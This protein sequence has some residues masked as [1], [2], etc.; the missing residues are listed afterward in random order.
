MKL[1]PFVTDL[2][3][4]IG[5]VVQDLR[6]WPVRGSRLVD[7]LECVLSVLLAIGFA[8]ALEVRHVGW[9]AFSGYMVM[10][11][12]IWRSFKRGSLRVIGTAAGA[13]VAW[14]LAAHVLDSLW[15]TS[16]ALLLV[17]F[18]TLYFT[19]VSPRGYA[20]L[21]TGLTF[22]MVLIDGMQHPDE[23]VQ[24]FAWTRF[25]EVAAGTVACLIVS[26]VSTL[27]VRRYMLN[28]RGVS[29]AYEWWVDRLLPWHP[30]AFVHAWQGA[31]AMALIPLAWLWLGLDSLSQSSVT[32]MVVMA[33]PLASVADNRTR[34]KLIHRFVGCAMGA[35]FAT[36]VLL[37]GRQSPTFILLAT[38]VAVVIGRHIENG[39][40]GIDYVGTQFVLAF[41]VVS[42]PDTYEALHLSVGV[43]R[44]AGVLLGIVLLEPVRMLLPVRRVFTVES[45]GRRSDDSS[46]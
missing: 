22:G 15:Q 2:G 4:L 5:R 39:K 32:I 41:L 24:V 1:V 7:E 3:D 13:A 36:I 44:V 34:T 23:A 38:A 45:D 46:E 18:V 43:E 33:I 35:L 37:V 8:H 19:M 12:H 6:S 21:F 20:W 29:M 42:V 31:I 30:A 26:A 10:R 16:I 40:H 17:T 27:T 14:Y 28:E 25:V 9:A 11:S